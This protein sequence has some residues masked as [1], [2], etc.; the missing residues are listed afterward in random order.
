MNEPP[1]GEKKE[2]RAATLGQPE[3]T[4]VELNDHAEV[5]HA[6]LFDDREDH[7]I[8][9]EIESELDEHAFEIACEIAA[10]NADEKR[11]RSRSCLI[12]T[13][14]AAWWHTRRKARR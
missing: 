13:P 14:L 10:I 1:P 6:Q 11:R 7:E 9:L 3:T 2:A 5:A 12:E 4:I 8:G